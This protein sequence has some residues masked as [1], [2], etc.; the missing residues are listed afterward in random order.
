MVVVII[1]ITTSIQDC[2]QYFPAITCFPS[3]SSENPCSEEDDYRQ[4][5]L[6]SLRRLERLD[7]DEFTEEERHEAEELAE[8]RKEEEAKAQVRDGV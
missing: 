8:Q 1:L 4:E 2:W 3:L 7:K 5:V 6:I